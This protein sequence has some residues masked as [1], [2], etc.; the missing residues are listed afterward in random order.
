MGKIQLSTQ[1][2]IIGFGRFINMAVAAGTL[3][4]LARILVDDRIGYGAICQLI[5]LYMVLSQIF[6]VG[7]PQSTFYF[8]P[9]F[10]GGERRGFLMQTIVLLML[11]GLLLGIGLYFGADLLGRLLRSEERLPDMLRIFAPYPLFMLPTLAVEGVLLH[12]SR[13][14]AI[15]I[16]NTAIR[17]GMFCALI[18]PLLIGM[19][20]LHALQ[21][22]V[23]VGGIMGVVALA[24]MLSA[25]R[26]LPLVWRP[27][28]LRHEWTF[29]LP[30]V[31]VTV[32]AICSH[33]LDRFI[34]SKL[35]PVSFGIYANASI[36]IPTVSTMV[37]ATSA[38]LLA[39][40]SRQTS[41]GET[42]ALLPLW[43]RAMT[44]L[45]VL[46]FTSLGFLAF[47]GHET[48][49]ILF[50]EHFAE[51]GLIFSILVW[52]IPLRLVTLQPLLVA[53]GATHILTLVT[54]FGVVFG[55]V[56]VTAGARLYGLP[57]I[58]GGSLV[59]GYLTVLVGIYI[60]AYRLTDIGLRKFL[61]WRQLGAILLAAL[62]AGT[63]S[64]LVGLLAA[65]LPMILTYLLA[66]LVF[67]ACYIGFLYLLNMHTLLL[68]EALKRR[69][70][71]RAPVAEEEEQPAQG[72]SSG[73]E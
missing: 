29:S 20:M 21:I 22:W 57:G 5:M 26:G 56:C 73:V 72:I 27:E 19:T 1:A 62:T 8:F 36:E 25:V 11:S 30:L 50:T 46:I 38:V 45:A 42:E 71:R 54:A 55:L 34:V 33:Y 35:G 32:L 49:I 12:A 44:K 52:V 3:M 58:A 59:A 51:S 4:M 7:L 41:R 9:R 63:I 66:L 64:R 67:L 60:F 39:E 13:P 16:F 69:F 61:P 31:G 47:W 14:V 23:A 10:E 28:M 43:H 15:V 68:P 24:L 17:L 48:M 6:A 70:H 2:A 18:I 40:F 53:M 37:N 65:G